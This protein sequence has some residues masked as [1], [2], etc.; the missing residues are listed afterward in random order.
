MHNKKYTSM[1]SQ[2]KLDLE[3]QKLYQ[4]Q[5]ND[6]INKEDLNSLQELLKT[7]VALSDMKEL[8]GKFIK[9]I[10]PVDKNN[11][12]I[13]AIKK[14]NVTIFKLI[15]CQ[16]NRNMETQDV[17]WRSYTRKKFLTFYN[18]FT[19]KININKNAKSH[20]IGDLFH[21]LINKSDE[22]FNKILETWSHELNHPKVDMKNTNKKQ[23]NPN[24]YLAAKIIK[25]N[26]KVTINT[27]I[28]LS[29]IAITAIIAPQIITLIAVLAGVIS[30]ALV[31]N[32]YKINKEM[33]NTSLKV[34]WLG[35]FFKNGELET[36]KA[37]IKERGAE[38][39]ENI[40]NKTT[41]EI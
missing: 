22:E 13:T 1:S 4:S 20:A 27:V 41:K 9:K 35:N 36:R 10:E 32:A 30:S 6:A 29:A 31:Y 8:N 34:S 3:T 19:S 11:A 38:L 2:Q 5:I 39:N 17:F 15:I 28:L 33:K 26:I 25:Q 40:E 7:G 18:F 12:V 16:H 23:L 21:V 37:H 14:G 24:N